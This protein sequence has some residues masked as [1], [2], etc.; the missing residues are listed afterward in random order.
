MMRLTPYCLKSAVTLDQPIAAIRLNPSS[1]AVTNTA[2]N[3]ANLLPSLSCSK[4]V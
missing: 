3:H 2:A 4:L 1:N